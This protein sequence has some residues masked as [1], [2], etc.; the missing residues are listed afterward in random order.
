MSNSRLAQQSARMESPSPRLA[1]SHSVSSDKHSTASTYAGLLPPPLSISPEPVFIAHSAASQIVTNDHDSSADA[2]LDQHGIEPSGETALVSPAALKLV[3]TFLD[4][5]VFNFLSVS[6]STSLVSLRLAVAEVLKSRLASDAVSGADAELREYLG[7]SEDDELLSSEREG[8]SSR[9]WDL[10]LVWKRTRLRCMVYS[11]L[12]DM[13]E[14]DEDRHTAEEHLNGSSEFGGRENESGV[15]SPAVAIFLTS[16]LE[17]M[18]EQILIVGGQAAYSRLRMKYEKDERDGVIRQTDIAERVVVEEVDMERVALDRK[19]GKL[20]RGWKKCIR[21]PISPVSMGHLPSTGTVDKLSQPVPALAQVAGVP[22]R[23]DKQSQK[24]AL[25]AQTEHEQ[26]AIIPLPMSVDDVREIEVPGLAPQSDDEDD[27]A[28]SETG[29]LPLSRRPKS[30]VVFTNASHNLPTPNSSQPPTPIFAVS[31]MKSRKRAN[32][33]PPPNPST[34]TSLFSQDFKEANSHQED[35]V[36]SKQSG[37]P[38]LTG[39]ITPAESEK[40][41]GEEIE[42]VSNKTKSAVPES[43]YEPTNGSMNLDDTSKDIDSDYEFVEEEPQIMTSSR[44][45]FG[46]RISP[47]DKE[48]SLRSSLRSTSIH[49]LRL[50]DVNTAKSPTTGSCKSSFDA[51]DFFAGR[52]ISMS[53]PNSIHSPIVSELSSRGTS[54]HLRSSN[55]SPLGRTGSTL[56]SLPLNTTADSIS[57]VDEREVA[58]EESPLTAVPSELAAAMQG[59][60]VDPSPTSQ[61]YPSFKPAASRPAPFVLAAPPTPQNY[62]EGI[63]GSAR[64]QSSQGR[65]S[66]GFSNSKVRAS[67][68]DG[69]TT[70]QGAKNSFEPPPRSVSRPIAN[71]V[72][73]IPTILPI[74]K[75]GN[76]PETFKHIPRSSSVRR[77]SPTSSRGEEAS[78]KTISDTLQKAHRPSYT[79]T[80]S[81]S[82]VHRVKQRRVSEES[83][84]SAMSSV[85]DS[86]SFEEL[87]RGGETIQYT[88]T[89]QNMRA[90]ESPDSPLSLN[91]IPV[92]RPA[93]NRTHSTSVSK[94]TGLHS[95][96][97]SDASKNN[98]SLKGT[99]R[100]STSSSRV[101]ANVQ[102]R[103]A[104]IEQD[105]LGDFADFIRSTGPAAP[106]KKEDIHSRSNSSA[107]SEISRPITSSTVHKG[108]NGTP[109][110]V[111]SSISRVGPVATLPT[112]SA[113]SAGRSGRPNKLQARDATVGKDSITDLIDFVRA[114]PDEVG[115][116]R[117]PRTVAPF[118]STMDSDQMSSFAGGKAIDAS[119]PDSRYS[120]ASTYTSTNHSVSSQTGLLNGASRVNKPIP[121]QSA[122]NVD[123]DEEVMPKRK[124]R[125]VRDP[126]A[127]DFSDEEDD[128]EFEPSSRPAPIKE[129][130]L[131]DFLRNVPPPPSPKMTSVFAEPPKPPKKKASFSSRFT[132]SGSTSQVQPP[133][134]SHSANS[135]TALTKHTP[136]A[137]SNPQLNAPTAVGSSQGSY[138]RQP[139]LPRATSGS[140][141]VRKPY[142]SR[143]PAPNKFRSQTSDLADFL[144]NS[145]PPPSIEPKPFVHAK[146][147][148]TFASRFFGR[149]KKS[150]A[151]F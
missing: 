8:Q 107:A 84:V 145:E 15:V 70:H 91:A 30:M 27:D 133:K 7:G 32:S 106:F 2:W 118:R 22:L 92:P 19:L 128:D 55:S 98:A 138:S 31:P 85:G 64:Q 21:S 29:K 99:S 1:R 51:T 53:R 80:S 76:S 102:P 52:G 23:D 48:S 135:R 111:S 120:Q 96:P 73:D 42:E 125:R 40:D 5:L 130:S 9:D 58:G 116:H 143:E 86:K 33:L 57:E 46:G 81:S 20:W 97:P 35:C 12:G 100:P 110:N 123:D 43:M 79:S 124:T 36:S 49:S 108:T 90:I 59:V 54:P 147:E 39:T 44:I 66:S 149:R 77:T 50:I 151:G 126:Y 3:N 137:P 41:A 89:P 104:R 148:S 103:D 112:R 17:F 14:E 83:G 95:H 18:G 134:T 117:I 34:F 109:R 45:S 65:S 113:S 67:E 127:I 78:R 114:G 94:H 119:L 129:E 140:N 146:E 24:K 136:L 16:I 26:A 28:T 25:N 142:E 141:D 144:R 69:Q 37:V 150:T 72:N 87:I 62:R 4:Q 38:V 101:R 75:E 60:D 47:D 56:S 131:A 6:K 71:P 11:S 93:T 121:T 63:K 105:S 13:E 115:G 122:M 68:Q 10:E 139:E 61:N 88:L 74:V 82:S 132:R